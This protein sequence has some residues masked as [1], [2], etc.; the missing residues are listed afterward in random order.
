[1]NAH[2]VTYPSLQRRL[3]VDRRSRAL[4]AAHHSTCEQPMRSPARSVEPPSPSRAWRSGMSSS[5]CSLSVTPAA[6]ASEGRVTSGGSR[7]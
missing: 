5:S 7:R 6:A 4:F 1:M 2:A 3:M